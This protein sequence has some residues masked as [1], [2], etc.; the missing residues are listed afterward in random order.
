[1]RKT[2]GSE[3]GVTPEIGIGNRGVLQGYTTDSFPNYYLSLP[4]N[5]CDRACPFA[6][7]LSTIKEV[8]ELNDTAPQP[9][10]DR[11]SDLR[12]SLYNHIEDRPD[13]KFIR[14]TKQNPITT[15]SQYFGQRVA[16]SD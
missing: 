3:L 14:Q 9:S 15:I 11:Q 16:T 13:Y 12:N 8:V 2:D 10:G 7:L 5:N 1:M 4:V 6:Y